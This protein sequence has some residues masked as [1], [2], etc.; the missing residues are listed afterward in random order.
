M[1]GGSQLHK[2]A[3][4][5]ALFAS[6]TG[7]G[8]CPLAA[9]IRFRSTLLHL[10]GDRSGRYGSVY[11]D[12]VI[13]EPVP[14]LKSQTAAKAITQSINFHPHCARLLMGS[15]LSLLCYWT[16]DALSSQLTSRSAFMLC[17]PDMFSRVLCLSHSLCLLRNSAFFT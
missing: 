13:A 1:N 4:G 16:P 17:P 15:Y 7:V 12:L 6:A 11:Y 9:T 8:A 2:S 10:L 3:R 14:G 5:S